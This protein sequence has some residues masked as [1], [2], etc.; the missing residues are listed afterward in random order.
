MNELSNETTAFEIRKADTEDS[1]AIL[2]CLA[3]TFE[4]YRSQYTPEGF[5]DTVLDA[6]TIQ[7]RMREMCVLVAESG[8]KIIGT[9]GYGV[10]GAEGHLR[11]MAVLPDWQGAGVASALLRAAEDGLLRAGCTCVTLDTTEPL[12]RATRFY[13]KQGF[14][15]SGR[16]S[17]FYGMP[18]YEYSKQFSG[19]AD[20][21][22]E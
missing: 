17:D 21:E 9:I 20:R 12:K 11:G 16:V 18:L 3:V 7:R 4:R 19:S 1:R 14:S 10:S 13:E 8:G 5:S 22:T 15:K 2:A 6:E